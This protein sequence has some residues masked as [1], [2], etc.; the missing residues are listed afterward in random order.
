MKISCCI[1]GG[2]FM[3]QGEK[4]VP[5]SSYDRLTEGCRVMRE[6]GYDAAEATVGLIMA[7]SEDEVTALQ[8]AYKA[9]EFSLDACN[10]FIPGHLPIITDEEGTQKLYAFVDDAIAR[11]SSIGI[12]YVVFGSG[13]VRRIPEGYDRDAAQ[14]KIDAFIR[15]VDACCEKYGMTCVIEP[16]NKAETNWCNSVAEGAAV[17][18][19]LNLKNVRLLADGYHMSKEGEPY[20]VLVDN[21]DILTHC[22]IASADRKIPGTTDYEAGFL[23]TLKNIGYDGIVT[24]ECGFGNFRKEAKIAAEWLRTRLAE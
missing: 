23:E 21:R 2:S 3:P 1:P 12:K 8:N 15:Q 11:M 10:S 19:R 7:L 9:G 16:L 6:L 22:H 20:S 5:M 17:V 14:E 4:E 13:A 24:V 18:R